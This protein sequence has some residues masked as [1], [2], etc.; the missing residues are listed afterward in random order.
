MF[1]R[2]L[3]A[4]GALAFSDLEVP[5]CYGAIAVVPIEDAAI[6]AFSFGELIGT[7]GRLTVWIVWDDGRESNYHGPRRP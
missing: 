7:D 6:P 5:S 1:D 3:A 2:L 4:W